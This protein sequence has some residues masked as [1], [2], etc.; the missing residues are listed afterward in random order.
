[1]TISRR[2]LFRT[3]EIWGRIFILADGSGRSAWR[4]GQGFISICPKVRIW[5]GNWTGLRVTRVKGFIIRML[6]FF[7]KPFCV[8]LNEIPNF[9]TFCGEM[10]QFQIFGQRYGEKRIEPSCVSL[11][12]VVKV[13]CIYERPPGVCIEWV[14]STSWSTVLERSQAQSHHSNWRNWVQW[15]KTPEL[16][17]FAGRPWQHHR[18]KA[19]SPRVHHQ[20][21]WLIPRKILH[22]LIF[23]L[24]TLFCAYPNKSVLS[25][26][27]CMK[28]ISLTVINS[29]ERNNMAMIYADFRRTSFLP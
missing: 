14:P 15:S 17:G 20:C 25:R 5:N 6:F 28:N 18:Q 26:S 12:L 22:L 10:G 23:Q 21:R 16:D 11:I 19:I 9:P 13:V 29:R 24:S 3:T 27:V 7:M 4:T 8:C 1:M 2:L